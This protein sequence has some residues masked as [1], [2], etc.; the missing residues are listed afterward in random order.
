MF[1][2]NP[3][4]RMPAMTTP[5]GDIMM[6]QAAKTRPL[7]D[8]D[9]AANTQSTADT[10]EIKRQAREGVTGNNPVKLTSFTKSVVSDVGELNLFLR[11]LQRA[12]GLVQGIA[13][14]EMQIG[15]V[16]LTIPP[17]KIEVRE[18]P[19]NIEVP[20][21]RTDG[22][23]II[24][25]GKGRIQITLNLVFNGIKDDINTKFRQLLAQFRSFPYVPV[26]SKELARI[27]QPRIQKEIDPRVKEELLKS[28]NEIAIRIINRKDSI[29][30][31]LLSPYIPLPIVVETD[32]DVRAAQERFAS[33]GSSFTEL[34]NAITDLVIAVGRVA[35]RRAVPNAGS[36][37]AQV[38]SI[39]AQL[40][41]E[42]DALKFDIIQADR[43]R[44]ALVQAE[45]GG[46]ID[47][48]QGVVPCVLDQISFQ[49]QPGKPELIRANLTMIYFNTLPYGGT[50][51]YKDVVGQPTIDPNQ[52]VFFNSY[53]STRWLDNSGAAGFDPPQPGGVFGRV[54]PIKGLGKMTNIN[55]RDQRIN[56]TYGVP[57][58]RDKDPEERKRTDNPYTM[59]DALDESRPITETMTIGDDTTVVRH[60]GVSLGNRLALQP[61]PGEV[62]PSCQ[63]IGANPS[64]VSVIVDTTSTAFIEK[65]N[66]MKRANQLMSTLGERSWRRTEM[67][68]RNPLINLSGIWAVQLDDFVTESVGPDITRFTITFFEHR[69]DL[70][71][72]EAINRPK[73]FSR[74]AIQDALDFLFTEA[75]PWGN[76]ARLLKKKGTLPAATLVRALADLNSER[77]LEGLPPLNPKNY[78]H[79]IGKAAKQL[80]WSRAAYETLFG[81]RDSEGNLVDAVI[82]PSIIRRAFF[83]DKSTEADERLSTTQESRDGIRAL[84]LSN[85]LQRPSPPDSQTIFLGS[86][87]PKDYPKTFGDPGRVAKL[88]YDRYRG[89][90][91]EIQVHFEE[92]YAAQLTA[93]GQDSRVPI[94][95]TFLRF[96]TSREMAVADVFEL[97]VLAEYLVRSSG[98]ASD[99]VTIN[100]KRDNIKVTRK[101]G[102]DKTEDIMSI[103]TLTRAVLNDL[104]RPPDAPSIFERVVGDGRSFQDFVRDKKSRSFQSQLYPDLDL[105]TYAEMLTPLLDAF[106]RARGT[107]DKK[108]ETVNELNEREQGI[109]RNFIPTYQEVAQIPPVDENSE[110]LAYD[111]SDTVMPDFLFFGRR[112][113]S[114][115]R[116]SENVGENEM[117]LSAKNAK[118]KRDKQT[119]YLNNVPHDPLRAE[120]IREI[121][122]S[123][124]GEHA[125]PKRQA[126]ETKVP[127]LG[128]GTNTDF[129]ITEAYTPARAKANEKD[130]GVDTQER[131]RDIYRAAI[132]QR[133]DTQLTL[134]RCFPTI[135]LF[136]IEE[137]T[138]EGLLEGSWRAIDDVY[139]FNSIV[140]CNVTR[141]KY[142]PDL[143]ELTLTNL[144]GNLDYDTFS[145]AWR[146]TPEGPLKTSVTAHGGKVGRQTPTPQEVAGPKE[147]GTNER[148]LRRFPLSEGT[149]I[150]IQLGYHSRPDYLR[151]VFTGKIAEV[152]QGDLVKIVAQGY[153]A[154]LLYPMTTPIGSETLSG[155]TQAAMDSPTVEH[156]GRWT[157]LSWMRLD[158]TEMANAKTTNWLTIPSRKLQSFFA[159]PKLRNVFATNYSS[160]WTRKIVQLAESNWDIGDGSKTAWDVIQEITSYQPGYVAAVVPFDMEA[161]LFLGRPEQPYNWTDGYRDQEFAYKNA[162]GRQIKRSLEAIGGD[163]D[164]ELRLRALNDSEQVLGP[165]GAEGFVTL[166]RLSPTTIVDGAEIVR[167]MS[168]YPFWTNF[169]RTLSRNLSLVS[170][171]SIIGAQ[172]KSG[173]ISAV[174]DT[175]KFF[176]LVQDISRQRA[177][178]ILGEIFDLLGGD[179]N[180]TWVVIVDK[181]FEFFNRTSTDL[182]ISGR[183]P[184][185][186]SR[187]VEEQALFS[188]FTAIAK[189]TARVGEGDAEVEQNRV[190]GTSAA[191]FKA[192]AVLRSLPD[193]QLFVNQ[194]WTGDL[195]GFDDI[196]E[197]FFSQEDWDVPEVDPQAVELTR[198][199]MFE[200]RSVF[201]TYLTAIRNFILESPIAQLAARLLTPTPKVYPFNP[202]K[203]PFRNYHLVTSV[204]DMIENQISTSRSTMWNG[205]AI[206]SGADRPLFLWADDGLYK[207]DR[208]LRYFHEANADIDMYNM[209]VQEAPGGL[210]NNKYYIGMSRLAQGLRF[211]YRG[212]L[213]LRGRPEIKPWD[214]VYMYDHYNGVAGP[215]EVERVTHH[216]S[217]QTGF[218][219]TITPNAVVIPND[220]ID[221][222]QIMWMG[223]TNGLTASALVVGAAVVTTA[224]LTIATGGLGLFALGIGLGAGGAA[225]TLADYVLTETTG[226]DIA[227]NFCGVG[228]HG[229][230][231]MPVKII[232]LSRKGAPWVA[233]MRGFGRGENDGIGFVFEGVIERGKQRFTDATAQAGRVIRSFGEGVDAYSKETKSY[234]NARRR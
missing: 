52:A 128:T 219:T 79:D 72:R 9:A 93:R 114:I 132:M 232:P 190:S 95:R 57:I 21:L 210:I 215:I 155:I 20:G 221:T 88:I 44:Q 111:L 189:T 102:K 35:V 143:A 197:A 47:P 91:A 166:P 5:D 153:L 81:R 68:I 28:I 151:T 78:Q 213:I 99:E 43:L 64:R 29:Q 230:L 83:L 229:G 161:T 188:E 134:R 169:A 71:A 162:R 211:M 154:E 59:A 227:G 195:V 58:F 136:F 15:L 148:D 138:G 37:Q 214:I 46:S 218:I 228:R 178:L 14:G 70:E 117:M 176:D 75:R 80:E 73:V 172:D 84:I 121:F 92:D 39:E 137:D 54:S 7:K 67:H 158:Q 48:E 19:Q 149:R 123:Q 173:Q 198:K 122:T 16:R 171:A 13:P 63:Y 216:F 139:G 201:P 193:P 180:D 101:D 103:L 56:L 66:R 220:Q 125:P 118:R 157:P 85:H 167:R 98:N 65:L 89:A 181:F 87:N 208:I 129:L 32:V 30:R 231:R 82:T 226:A 217:A 34:D 184:I 100:K 108:L 194:V 206:S 187:L 12:K 61:I 22:S 164:P 115:D 126:G 144:Q 62:Y 38:I 1:G 196:K 60:V 23:T 105:P 224:V 163:L 42:L 2:P 90:R 8:P 26:V 165:N 222:S 191:T 140:D 112:V 141:H 33:A 55:D 223:L 152:T 113:S 182:V 175:A 53:L 202:R 11:D 94:Q 205:V 145:T 131:A 50:L 146:N 133:E 127:R 76:G 225:K 106:I 174:G 179:D 27:V 192:Q 159:E 107:P 49:S 6:G 177:G 3:D 116:D 200:L 170:T 18:I 4:W 104:I 156:F 130:F 120:I 147:P 204:D 212:Q 207:G 96:D 150:V 69:V 203:K 110:S 183:D 74:D 109:I 45:I 86:Q 168:A 233:A 186:L 36:I 135:R 31:E 24:K 40:T 119:G 25:S 10:E 97:E 124:Q 77:A 234:R 160:F 185:A 41:E 199:I 142:Q 209:T 17:E 51:Q